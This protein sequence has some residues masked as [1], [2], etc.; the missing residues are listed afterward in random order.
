[1][2][3]EEGDGEAHCVVEGLDEDEDEH[4]S[5]QCERAPGDD[6]DDEADQIHPSA[7]ETCDG[8]D[9]DCDGRVD[10]DDGLEL[11]GQSAQLDGILALDLAWVPGESGIQVDEQFRMAFFAQDAPAGIWSGILDGSGALSQLTMADTGFAP[12]LAGGTTTFGLAF[13]SYGHATFL[14][15]QADPDGAPFQPQ[16]ISGNLSAMDIARRSRGEW[17]LGISDSSTIR[18]D[19]YRDDGSSETGPML[20]FNGDTTL[21]SSWVRIAGQ[22]NASAVVWQTE[23]NLLRRAHLNS[24]LLGTEGVSFGATGY[25]PD[26]VATGSGYA[27]AWA[28]DSGIGIMRTATGGAVLC[29][30]GLV[31]LG[32]DQAS[33]SHRVALADSEF[34]TLALVTSATGDKVILVR[35]GL[36]C[37]PSAIIPVANTPEAGSPAIAVGN[38]SVALAWV[39]TSS[40]IAYTRV[41]GE[42][43]CE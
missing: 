26:I 29:E 21:N 40:S 9:N 14:A 24:S 11:A 16:F 5:A 28:V 39:D 31:P 22:G 34:G 8:L 35:F 6:C 38:G 10:L 41:V 1:V 20:T 3:C 4:S 17:I 30:N 7:Q 42:R 2:R 25:R 43:L 18:V 19:V 23:P 15:L 12:R 27:I 32:L 36:D 33:D 13:P 37:E